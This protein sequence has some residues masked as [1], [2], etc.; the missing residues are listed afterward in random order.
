VVKVY[1][2]SEGFPAVIMLE[3]GY[4]LKEYI[5]GAKAD[6]KPVEEKCPIDGMFFGEGV[7]KVFSN[8][9]LDMPDEWDSNCAV[10]LVV[11]DFSNERTVD[12]ME[13]I[14]RVLATF[15]G[16][17]RRIEVTKGDRRLTK[18]SIEHRKLTKISYGRFFTFWQRCKSN[19]KK[20]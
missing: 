10:W 9:E 13:E 19:A 16:K 3:N 4:N 2:V 7:S 1:S 18:V 12:F 8:Y 5:K 14:L 6:W 20:E 15:E 11:G 17:G